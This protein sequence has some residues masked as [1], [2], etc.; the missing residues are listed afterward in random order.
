MDDAMLAGRAAAGDLDSFGQLYD[1]Y[2]GRV[3]D[4]VW[5]VLRDSDEAAEVTREVFAKVVQGLPELTRATSFKSALFTAAHYA[6]VERAERL[7]RVVPLPAPVYE[8]AFGTFD[9]PD[10][11]RVENPQL[12]AGDHE[13]AP[14]VWEAAAALN[15][16]DYALLDLH[17][18]QGVGASDLASIIGVS[19]SSANT[20]VSRMKAA[21]EDVVGSYVLARR[22]GNDCDKLQ[23]VLADFEF[24]P[25]TDQVRKAVDAHVSGCERCRQAR[26]ALAAPLEIYAGFAP[27]AAPMAL[28]GDTW[29]NIADGWSRRAPAGSAAAAA[30][31][32]GIGIV[33]GGGGFDGTAF[34]GAGASGDEGWNRQKVVWFAGGVVGL[35][36]FA[37]AGGAL[38][39]NVFDGGGGDAGS[40]TPSV[41]RTAA[42]TRTPTPVS[43]LTPGVAIQT[44]TVDLTPPT[45]APT[46]TPTQEPTAEPATATPTRTPVA[47]KTHTP[48]PTPAGTATKTPT[49]GPSDT[50]VPAGTPTKTPTPP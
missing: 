46:D 3:Y 35:L 17:I 29:R 8:E 47:L 27:V 37:L 45:A 12:V 1:S 20:M 31:A 48:T 32:G 6:A 36:V 5:R 4:F 39:A 49:G 21:A 25:Y 24:P 33:G 30:G 23:A 43:T 9:V 2:F 7:G 15:P 22:G 11:C 13:L 19:K 18:R 26:A 41:T 42:A 10:P 34:S 40:N 38:I 16:R 28:K 50:P 44:P 14:L